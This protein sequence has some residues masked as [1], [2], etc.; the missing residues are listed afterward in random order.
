M[1]F[2]YPYK[3]YIIGL[4]IFTVFSILGFYD[5]FVINNG[6]LI[7]EA[8]Y[9]IFCTILSLWYYMW[10][11]I[12]KDMYIFLDNKSITI[13]NNKTSTIYNVDQIY[14]VVDIRTKNFLRI[15]NQI[16]LITLTGEKICITSEINSFKKFKS[17]LHTM[18][19][20]QY[21]VKKEL[22][23]PKVAINKII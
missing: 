5:I 16:Y 23:P 13:T 14:K 22:L 3:L 8:L 2:E 7:L 1:K 9:V 6:S 20:D 17:Q 12:Y 15:Q 21:I 4:C 18:F 19:K 11:I 10:F